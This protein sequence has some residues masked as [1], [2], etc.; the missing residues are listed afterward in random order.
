[1]NVYASASTGVLD[2]SGRQY[3][4]SW[5][6]ARYECLKPDGRLIENYGDMGPISSMTVAQ[7]ITAGTAIATTHAAKVAANL[8]L[9]IRT[10]CHT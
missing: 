7:A 10:F 5:E 9:G 6:K 2:G 1:M 8:A 3:V 4:V